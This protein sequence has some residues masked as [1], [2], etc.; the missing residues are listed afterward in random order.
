MCNSFNPKISKTVKYCELGNTGLSIPKVALGCGF[1]GLFSASEARVVIDAAI[2]RGIYLIDCA[3][4]YRLRDGE[5][6]E[7]VLGAAIK[8]KRNK[9]VITSK[10]GAPLTLDS[11]KCLCGASSKTLFEC[12]DISLRR[13]KTDYIDC[14]LLH[15]PDSTTSM[16]EIIAGFDKLCRQ[17]KKR[18]YGFCNHDANLLLK[19]IAIAKENGLIEP[20]VIQNPYN[21]L[22]RGVENQLLD[23][24]DNYNLGFLAYSPLAT[25]LLSGSFSKDGT[26]PQKSTWSY[27]EKYREYL[28]FFFRGRI[29]EI[30][31][32]IE[33]IASE[34]HSTSYC[35]ALAWV[36]SKKQVTSCIVGPDTIT[37]LDELLKVFSC[38]IPEEIINELDELSLGMNENFTAPAVASKVDKYIKERK[39]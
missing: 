16:I 32:R 18:C 23:V 26:V 35:V 1:R 37:E 28:E 9:I 5:Y 15:G 33:E 22:N 27:N 31:G 21:L 34:I 29:E 14:L 30:V 13:L 8:N 11:G 38:S 10:Y 39:D 7:T 2:D 4:V 20:A 19:A 3:N 25:G 12:V 17:G 6:S 36:L 24:V